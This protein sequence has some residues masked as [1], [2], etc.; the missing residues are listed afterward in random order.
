[1]GGREAGME[2]WR[3]RARGWKTSRARETDLG[4]KGGIERYKIFANNTTMPY[5]RVH[6][7]C[8]DMTVRCRPVECTHYVVIRKLTHTKIHPTI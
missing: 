8:C 4:N 5:R 7:L 1:M 3:E 6:P 2:G